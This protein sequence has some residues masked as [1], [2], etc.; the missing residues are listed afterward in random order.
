[1]GIASAIP[2]VGLVMAKVFLKEEELSLVARTCWYRRAAQFQLTLVQRV[3][4]T[5]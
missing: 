1:M 2:K 3:V 5:Q 4:L